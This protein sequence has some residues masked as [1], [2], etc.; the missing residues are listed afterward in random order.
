LTRTIQAIWALTVEDDGVLKAARKDKVVILHGDQALN[1]WLAWVSHITDLLVYVAYHHNP[2]DPA[3]PDSPIPGNRSIFKQSILL[4]EAPDASVYA[5][6]QEEDVEDSVCRGRHN[7]SHG[8]W[9]A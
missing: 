4:P 2:S 1:G 9:R 8:A 5:I 3:R 7:L 6:D